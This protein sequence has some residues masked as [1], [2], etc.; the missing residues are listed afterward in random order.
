MNIMIRKRKFLLNKLFIL[1]IMLLN[2][3]VIAAQKPKVVFATHWMPQAQFAGYYVAEDQGY[4]DDAGIDVE[5]I[6]A[7]T[8][9][10]S[11][12]ILKNGEADIVSSFLVSAMRARVTGLDLVNITQLSQHSAILFISKKSG[13]IKSLDDFNGKKIGVWNKDFKDMPKCLIDEKK[14]DVE[15]IPIL[16]SVNLFLMGGIDVLTVMYYNEY[17]IVYLSGVNLDELNTFF[18][19]DYG[20]DIPEDGLY[21]LQSTLDT[22]K[23][24][25]TAFTNASLKGWEYASNHK[26]YTVKLVVSIMR[27]ANIPSSNAHQSWMLDKILDLQSIKG[28]S[29]SNTELDENDFNQV[30]DIFYNLNICKYP[31]TYKDFFKPLL[32]ISNNK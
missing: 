32:P 19:S 2:C 7:T 10:N 6:H 5:I 12:E 13:N 27:E 23:N 21:T 30:M 29:I 17:D 15:W 11:M 4:Y 16:S 28:K 3:L 8:T 25:L 18:I 24:D 9:L 26:E 20:Y 14:I 31:F 1:G 22:R